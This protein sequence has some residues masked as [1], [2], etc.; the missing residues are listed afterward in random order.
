MLWFQP[1]ESLE[2]SVQ[3][4]FEEFG[5]DKI[6]IFAASTGNTPG[7][8]ASLNQ[9]D[10]DAVKKIKDYE[11]V[12]GMLFKNSKVKFKEESVTVFLTGIDEKQSVQIFRELNLD[13]RDGRPFETSADKIV[14]GPRIADQLYQRK[15]F[16]GN[17]LEIEGKKFEVT[18]ITESI[19]NPQ[20]D[21]S[22]YMPLSAMRE[23]FDDQRTI[24][25]IMAKVKP[26]LNIDEAAEK[27]EKALKRVRSE[28]SFT[29]ATPE[30]L[31]EQLGT[32]LSILQGVLIGIATISIVVGS[33]GIANSMY[34]SVL[35]R[36]KDIGI[37][38]S[39]GAPNS[40]IVNIFLIEAA[41]TGFV[42]GIIGVTVGFG[43]SKA[44]ELAAAQAGFTIL[45]IKIEPIIALFGIA[46]ATTIGTASG[47]LPARKASNMKP[48]DA[49][50]K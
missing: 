23:L 38:K 12:A 32:I 26:G 5:S 25:F 35:E 24:S 30:Q 46:F 16:T 1:A 48:A 33:V 11:L 31:L 49:L 18:G 13:F 21:S 47:Y 7:F 37:M 42:G 14:L 29:V 27:T 28:E 22:I 9:D 34:T 6:N 39:L 50:R 43:I 20:D 17:K 2:A 3:E 8:D 45:Q 19:G 36:V 4:Q 41:L 40:E 10:L 15:V 44:I